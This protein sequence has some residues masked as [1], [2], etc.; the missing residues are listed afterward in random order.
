MFQ[1]IIYSK[2]RHRSTRCW[3]EP[4][5]LG[6]IVQNFI[7]FYDSVTISLFPRSLVLLLPLQQPVVHGLPYRGNLTSHQ[8]PHD[9]IANCYQLPNSSLSA[10]WVASSQ[11][12]TSLHLPMKA[13]LSARFVVEVEVNL[14]P[15]ISRPVRLGIGPPYGTLNQILSCSSFFCWQLLDYSS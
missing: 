11:W 9:G 1:D 5:S 10:S 15:T 12:I 8:L 3:T 7:M 13:V 6:L 4:N 2:Y 14:R